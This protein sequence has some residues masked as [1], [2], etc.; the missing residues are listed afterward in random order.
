ME[1]EGQCQ[2]GQH[3]LSA[4]QGMLDRECWTESQCNTDSEIDTS[5]KATREHG[6]LNNSVSM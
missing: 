5:H 6:K 3:S 2:E 4:G 1:E